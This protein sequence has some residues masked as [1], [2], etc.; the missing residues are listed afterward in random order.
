[1]IIIVGKKNWQEFRDGKT[2]TLRRYDEDELHHKFG[3]D[4]GKEIVRVV[5]ETF[6]RG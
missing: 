4:P 1:M 3:D 6:G 2:K 5:V